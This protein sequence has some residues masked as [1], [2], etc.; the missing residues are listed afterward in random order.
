MLGVEFPL[1]PVPLGLLVPML[2]EFPF[3]SFSLQVSEIMSTLETVKVL[4]ELPLDAAEL[5]D[6]A[7]LSH[8]PL[9]AT[10]CPACAD[11]SWPVRLTGPFLV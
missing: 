9:T 4:P 1:E 5:L 7:P 11:T 6:P 3:L 8:V 10:S 2:P